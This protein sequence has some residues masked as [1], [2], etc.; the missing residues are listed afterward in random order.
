M[1]DETPPY[2]AHVRHR[3]QVSPHVVRVTLG[4]IQARADAPSF[5]STGRADEFF[6]L[7]VPVPGGE[8]AKRYYTVR[9]WRPAAGEID[10]DLLLH[11]PGAASSWADRASVGDV[12]AFDAPRGHYAPPA[13]A[14]WVALCG[15]ATAL[16]AVGRILDERPAEAPPVTVV[17]SVDDPADRPALAARD[18][19]V[20]RWV[21]SDDVVARTLELT[22]TTQ[23]GYLWFA[24]E[25][26]DMRVV[27]QRLRRELHWPVEQWCTM[28]YWRRDSEKWLQRLHSDGGAVLAQLEALYASGG[29]EEDLADRAED[30]LAGNGLL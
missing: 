15:D 22:S 30:L 28:G 17:L 10:V 12:V 4:G 16:P 7:W 18:D 21:D 26:S 29:D 11:G 27:R 24:G 13:A 5:V 3:V 19:D 1:T 2:T 9:A 23:P 25:A 20:V 8:P 6:G 14:R